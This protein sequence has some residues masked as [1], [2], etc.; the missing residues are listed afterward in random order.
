MKQTKSA[1]E[2]EREYAERSRI[3][4]ERLREHGRVVVPCACGDPICE[5]WQSVN[6]QDYYADHQRE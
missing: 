2:F 5:G 3:S 1:A 4:V 6:G